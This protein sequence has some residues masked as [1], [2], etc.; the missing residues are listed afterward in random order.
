MSLKIGNYTFKDSRPVFELVDGGEAI[1][2]TYGVPNYLGVNNG[3]S[4]TKEYEG[5]LFYVPS[6]LVGG[7]WVLSQIAYWVLWE[8]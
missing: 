1:Y 6:I 8:H 7:E 5:S 4:L 2:D 3:T